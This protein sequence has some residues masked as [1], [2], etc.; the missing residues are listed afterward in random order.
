MRVCADRY[1]PN[2]CLQRRLRR[3]RVRQPA[4]Q[5]RLTVP[6]S[7]HFSHPFLFLSPSRSLCPASLPQLVKSQHV[8]LLDCNSQ[9]LTYATCGCALKPV[10]YIKPIKKIS[11]H[12]PVMDWNNYG[13]SHF[14]CKA[15]VRQRGRGEEWS[16]K[17]VCVPQ[18]DGACDSLSRL[19][20]RRQTRLVTQP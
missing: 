14:D 4:P 8:T 10:N 5:R 17:N 12:R 3:R 15:H 9:D 7:H 20:V 2:T 19:P 16:N 6:V 1:S 11:Y 13:G 18:G